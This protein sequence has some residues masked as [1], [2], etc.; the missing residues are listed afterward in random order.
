M[1]KKEYPT[2]ILEVEITDFDEKG[3][4]F[5][6]YFHPPKREG[7]QGKQLQLMVN[8]AIPGDHVRVTIPNAKGRR[9]AVVD[10]DEI[11]QASPDRNLDVTTEI[12]KSGGAPLQYMNYSA[13]LD[14]KMKYVQKLFAE[15]G[16]VS[17]TIRPIIAMDDPYRY[18]N[19]M[20]IT[21]GADGAIGMHRLGNYRKIID[22]KDSILA[23]KIMIRV[24]EIVAQWQK[25][26]DLPSYNKDTREGILRHLL[27][28]QSFATK[29]LLI[30]IYGTVAYKQVQAQM[31]DL[32][33]RLVREI[34]DLKSFSYAQH[35]NPSDRVESEQTSVIYGRDF[36]Y[37]ELGGL[38]YRIWPDTFFQAS[39]QQAEKMIE[40]VLQMAQVNRS[41]RVLD[42]FCGVGTFSLPLAQVAKEVAGIEIVESSVQSARRNATDNGIDNTYFLASDVRRGMKKIQETWGDPDLLVLDPPRSGAGGKVMRAIGRLGTQ[43]IIYISCNPKTLVEDI[44]HLEAFGY[45]LSIVQ[46]IDQF[47]HT[48][49]VESVV[50]MT[51]CE[52]L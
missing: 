45:Q 15:S 44:K 28:R 17:R 23:P 26:V 21:F 48:M 36:I 19:K 7:Q 39:V 4:G 30:V 33:E 49:H 42:L 41:M 46:P 22:M 50:L 40:C 10:Y 47:A 16:F 24:K 5:A 11:I 20:D 27:M 35:S 6:R 12:E 31:E 32:K 52:T 2:E 25:D 43:K 1:K 3:R 13:Q 8:Q 51:K 34:P 29:E 38:T 14:Y 18:R 9:K 37:D